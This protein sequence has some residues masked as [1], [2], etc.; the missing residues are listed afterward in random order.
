MTSTFQNEETTMR[1]FRDENITTQTQS[2]RFHNIRKDTRK[3]VFFRKGTQHSQNRATV[4]EE[5][6]KTHKNTQ[7]RKKMEKQQKQST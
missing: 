4:S 1:T 6:G 7:K 5:H 2:Y 3:S